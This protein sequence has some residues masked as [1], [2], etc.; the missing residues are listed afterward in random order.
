MQ[1]TIQPGDQMWANLARLIRNRVPDRNGNVLPTDATFG[2]YDLQQLNSGAG[3][4]LQANLALDSTFG[5]AAQPPLATC[6]GYNDA[7]YDP[8]DIDVTV[9][10]I[11]DTYI[12]AVDSCNDGGFNISS[13]FTSWWS[14]S[15]SIADGAVTMGII[16]L[17][18]IKVREISLMPALGLGGAP[19]HLAWR[20]DGRFSKCK[21]RVLSAFG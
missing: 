8:D 18:K 13:D 3:S 7:S 20:T 12:S 9:N 17:F 19:A 15:P 5:L 6:C 11:E 10:G 1:Q 21:G 14:S 2:T 4:L 16:R